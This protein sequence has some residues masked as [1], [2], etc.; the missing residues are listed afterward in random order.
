[1]IDTYAQEEIDVI[2]KH[3]AER[4]LKRTR[5]GGPWAMP[6]CLDRDHEGKCSVDTNTKYFI[7]KVI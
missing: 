5:C 7:R 2:A 4:C 3:G 6:C 1:M